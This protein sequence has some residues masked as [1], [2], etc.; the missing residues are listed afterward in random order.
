[1]KKM[2]FVLTLLSFGVFN[3]CSKSPSSTTTTTP[4]TNQA[5]L[6]AVNWKRDSTIN[7]DGSKV[8][9]TGCKAKTKLQFTN[10]SIKEI[11]D[12]VY[13]TAVSANNLPYS[14]NSNQTVIYSIWAS[15]GKTGVDTINILFLDSAKLVVQSSSVAI[16]Q[17]YRFGKSYLT[18]AN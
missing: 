3:S 10:D 5:K 7:N 14:L 16:P 12:P 6:K 2:S 13:C 1:M 18:R 17:A 15:G 4:T 9:H 11:L 8:V